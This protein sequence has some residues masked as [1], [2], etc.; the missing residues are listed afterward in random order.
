MEAKDKL[1]S[2]MTTDA[3]ARNIE[4]LPNEKLEKII[5]IC[6]GNSLAPLKIQMYKGSCRIEL[7]SKINPASPSIEVTKIGK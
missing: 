6:V 1:N 3:N 4:H 5:K 7:S 2:L